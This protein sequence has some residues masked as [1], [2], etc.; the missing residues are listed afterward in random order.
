MHDFGVDI[1]CLIVFKS[2]TLSISVSANATE[3]CATEDQA[4]HM[5][6]PIH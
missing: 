2:G 5:M 1:Q 3:S 4:M 6:R